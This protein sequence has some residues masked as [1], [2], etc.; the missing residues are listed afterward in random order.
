MNILAPVNLPRPSDCYVLRGRYSSSATAAMTP[1]ASPAS[2]RAV[3]A[4]SP[5][6]VFSAT[7]NEKVTSDEPAASAGSV[8]ANPEIQVLAPDWVPATVTTTTAMPAQH[9]RIPFY[10]TGTVLSS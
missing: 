2:P 9:K 7:R 4:S 3:D 5:L 1:T 8:G 6:S 10:A